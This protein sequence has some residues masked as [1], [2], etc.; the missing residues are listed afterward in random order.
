MKLAPVIDLLTEG[1]ERADA[2]GVA[3]RAAM[4]PTDAGNARRLAAV[5]GDDLRAVT[6]TGWVAWDGTRW[7][8]DDVEATTAMRWALKTVA[9]IRDE[10]TALRAAGA[11]DAALRA[12]YRHHLNSQNRPRLDAMLH[13]ARVAMQ[14]HP[15]DLDANPDLLNT[16][17]G[18]VHLPTGEIHPPCREDFI[19]RSTNVAPRPGDTPVWDAFLRKVLPDPDLRAYV[20]REAGYCLTGHTHEQTFHVLH[21]A[22]ANGKS[23]FERTLKHVCGEYATSAAAETFMV[24]RRGGGDTRSDLVRLRGARLV[25]FSET[26][27]G[28]RFDDRLIKEVTG[29][30]AITARALYAA[31]VTFTPRFKLH[32]SC[33]GL[34]RFDGADFAMRRRL[35]VV[36]FGVQIPESEQD[37]Q[38]AARL[39]AE[40]PGILAWAIE[41]AARWYTDGLG[42]CAAVEEASAA[43]ADD[44]DPIGLF[45]AD[46]CHRSP[47]AFTPSASIATAYSEWADAN[48]Q[49]DLG[50]KK[51]G[52]GLARHGLVG[53][54]SGGQ[55]GWK[56][57]ELR[58]EDTSVTDRDGSSRHFPRRKDSGT[59]GTTRHDLSHGP[60]NAL[61]ADVLNGEAA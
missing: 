50:A 29:G 32:A 10:D 36:P 53:V 4:D 33:N 2:S 48:R 11:D 41:G 13:L 42:T 21:G 57:L 3:I 45:L 24:S 61:T 18:T 6:G 54:R 31:E 16:P 30:E 19:T 8:P 35:R 28:L 59:S 56:G 20:Q 51:I 23:V 52:D 38:L 39:A 46:R 7:A 12:R 44:M 58:R 34:P 55:R 43:S 60:Q 47:N 27:D 5:A 22:G 40:A 1:R 17:A 9:S 14:V 15:D 25:S 49:P 37:P 26:S